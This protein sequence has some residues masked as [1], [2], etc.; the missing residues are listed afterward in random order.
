MTAPD[1]DRRIVRTLCAWFAANRRDLPWRRPEP[2]GRRDAYRSLV[3]EIMLQQTQVARAAEKFGPFVERFPTV[4]DLAEASIDEVLALWSG[5]GYYRRARSLHRCA[6]EIVE[7]FGAVP[8]SAVDLQTLPG[9]G[10]Y[11][12][13]AVASIVFDEPAPIVDGNVTR[14]LLR[15][16]GRDIDPG[17][18]ESA[19]FCW[20]RAE[21][22][23]RSAA[24]SRA[25]GVSPGVFNEAMM[26]LGAL[27]CTPRSPGC[28]RCPLGTIC[29]ARQQG[30]QH[31][32]P[33]PKR[34]GAKPTLHM[35]C[36]VVRDP[37]GRLLVEQRPAR[38]LW[39]GLW[40]P[41]TLESDRPIRKSAVADHFGLASGGLCRDDG[42]NRQFVWATSHRTVRVA[43]YRS[44][45]A[46]A[47]AATQCWLSERQLARRA[48]GSLQRRILLGDFAESS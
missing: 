27:V 33:R 8:A 22:L 11:T 41:P 31:A 2:S 24:R 35:A 45:S 13:G 1:R 38:G 3:S 37:R 30:K 47:G 17:S 12:A 18:R 14:V 26:E 19:S 25:A 39:A 6:Q 44:P 28:D 42:R 46:P 29:V 48:L 5:L 16:E 43:V 20:E 36:V 21:R 40:Q 23:V 32:I 7:R 9:I 15:V 4:N 34:A 10:R